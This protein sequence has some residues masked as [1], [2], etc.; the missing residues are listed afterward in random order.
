[1]RIVLVLPGLMLEAIG[2]LWIGQ[3]LGYVRWPASSLMID[4]RPWVAAGAVLMVV[5]LAMIMRGI[6][7][8][9]PAA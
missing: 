2:M 1:M 8:I 7:P 5:G 3:G 4:Q 6:K 9:P